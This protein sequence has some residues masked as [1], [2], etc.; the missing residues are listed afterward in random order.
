MTR[1]A[2]THVTMMRSGEGDDRGINTV[3]TGELAS[4]TFSLNRE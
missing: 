2:W 3:R 4:L 1:V